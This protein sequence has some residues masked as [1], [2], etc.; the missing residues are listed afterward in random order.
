MDH[1]IKLVV[2]LSIGLTCTGAI[3]ARQT[4]SVSPPLEFKTLVIGAPTTPDEVEKALAIPCGVSFGPGAAPCTDLDKVVQQARLVKCGLGGHEVQVCNGTTTIAGS[5][6][7]VNV[8]IGSD[9]LLQRIYLTLSEIGYDDVVQALISKFGE[10]QHGSHS[11]L[12]NGFGTTFQQEERIW[13][14]PN[15]TQLLLNKYAG[16]VDHSIVYFS[17]QSDRD[18]MT[19]AGNSPSNDL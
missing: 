10:A 3:A 13:V 7:D 5:P 4:V 17:T 19:G 6:A 2:V 18:L 15:R 14:G 8:V 16:D 12:Q 1:R 11:T 9:G